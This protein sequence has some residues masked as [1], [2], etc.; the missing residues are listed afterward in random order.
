MLWLFVQQSSNLCSRAT[1]ASPTCEVERAAVSDDN[2]NIM[3]INF[4][5]I[6]T[7]LG[8]SGN[9][10]VHLP[11]AEALRGFGKQLKHLILDAY[12]KYYE[13]EDHPAVQVF[14]E[15]LGPTCLERIL[16]SC[17]A[18]ETLETRH[19]DFF[20]VFQKVVVNESVTSLTIRFADLY[21]DGFDQIKTCLP[22]LWDL[23]VKSSI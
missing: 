10:R 15:G 5:R 23:N 18:L 3:A 7:I 9:R 21:P 17:P 4:N 2:Y 11:H 6:A 13:D 19:V 8:R 16:E 20:E 1:D 22:S 14:E 12:S